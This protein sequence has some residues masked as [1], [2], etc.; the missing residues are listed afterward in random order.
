M[1]TIDD[2]VEADPPTVDVSLIVC[3]RNRASRLP[4]VLAQVSLLDPPPGGWE[5]ILVDSASTDETPD[6]IA[7]FAAA[8]TFPVRYLRTDMPGLAHA[9]NVGLA[10]ANGAILAFT[11][12]DCYP[13][14]DYLRTLK[15]TFEGH[16]HLGFVGGRAI[17]QDPSDAR[18]GVKESD[19]PRD[20]PP[21]S[22][23]AAGLIHG[24]NMAVR[25]E[26]VTTIGGFDP[27]LGS[28]RWCKAGEDT[29]Y[30]A[31]ISWA[32]WPGRYEPALVVAHH[33]GRKPG[34]EVDRHR[35]AYDRGRG[36]YY[37][38]FVLDPRSRGTYLRCWYW[39]SRKDFG[40]P[41]IGRLRRELVGAAGYV[42]QRLIRPDPTPTFSSRTSS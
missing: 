11:D 14:V 25:R 22:F 15:A 23:V 17:L 20:I 1:T 16:P 34:P 13:R 24:A 31:R 27:L 35:Q 19:A 5:L 37:M 28:G 39:R 4:A 2:N 32:G 12:D 42:A 8:A 21:F 36:A 9:R 38:K 33:H 29:D 18:I 10:L 7:S 26:V 6:Q 30:I 3:T 40:M 41:T